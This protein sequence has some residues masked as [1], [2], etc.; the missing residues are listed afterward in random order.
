MLSG[1]AFCFFKIKN[2]S[3]V[4]TNVYKSGTIKP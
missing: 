2:P 1:V 3:N 4:L